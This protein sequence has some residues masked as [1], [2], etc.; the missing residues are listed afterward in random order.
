MHGLRGP[1]AVITTGDVGYGIN[2]LQSA[3]AETAR[4]EINLF[5]TT[6]AAVRWIGTVHR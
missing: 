3:Y 6:A 2:R 5:R 1:A 4:Y